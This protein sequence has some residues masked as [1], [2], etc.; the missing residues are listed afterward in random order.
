MKE[1]MTTRDWLALQRTKLANERTFL[2]YLRT[3][4]VLLG[5]GMTII[6]LDMFQDLWEYGVVLCVV[7]PII[8]TIGIFRNNRVR[9]AI[10][11]RYNSNK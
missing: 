10:N 11:K 2:A 8:F 4:F 5:T 7:A 9:K 3:S 1:E 6:K